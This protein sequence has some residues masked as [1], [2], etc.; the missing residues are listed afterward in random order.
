MCQISVVVEKDGVEEMVMEDVTNLVVG[1]D[2]LEISNLFEGPKSINQVVIR[3]IDF[4]AGKVLL[5]KT[6]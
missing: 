5:Q 1:S 4:V 6:G 2:N 3:S